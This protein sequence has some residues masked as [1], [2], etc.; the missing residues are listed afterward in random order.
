MRVV[1][2]AGFYYPDSVGGTEVYVDFLAQGLRDQGIDTVVAAPAM[3]SLPL[4]YGHNGIDVFRY[5]TPKIWRR[6]ETTGRVP[7]RFFEVFED[8]LARQRADVYH[9]HSWTTGCGLW[10]IETAKRLGLKT[11]LSVH[12]PANICMRGTM[13]LNGRSACDGQI[14]PARC[15]SCWLQSKGVPEIASWPL[16]ALPV[17]LGPLAS[18]PHVG[19]ALA[20][21]SLAVQKRQQIDYMVAAADRVVAVCG[22]LHR[23]LRANGV[24]DRKLVLNRQGVRS[25][26]AIGAHRCPEKNDTVRVG[27]LGR[28][29]RAKGIHVLVDAFKRLSLDLSVTL[30]IRAADSGANSKFKTEVLRAASCDPRIRFR[31]VG[32]EVENFLASI[33]VLA[34]PSQWMETGPLVVLEAFAAG[35]PVIGSDLGGIRELVCHD[36]DGLLVAH[37]DVSAWADALQRFVNDDL[38]RMRLRSG[39]KPVRTMFDVSREMAAIYYDLTTNSNDAA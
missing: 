13:L 8:W 12:V 10:H 39:I 22:W 15:A 20:A 5:P 17:S 23:A 6:G 35:I 7:H 14:V 16:A 29:D 11:V 3:S 25:L 19:P 28:W 31:E 18:V 32:N 2:C 26:S 4:E 9:Q 27:F 38:L 1:Q 30:D 36:Q 24:P 37:D 21:R 34:V 33:D